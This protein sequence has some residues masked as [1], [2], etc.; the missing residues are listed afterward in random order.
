LNQYHTL[1]IIALEQTLISG[2][3]IHFSMFFF[4]KYLKIIM[5]F[6][7]IIFW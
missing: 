4:F 2:W 6:L 3:I 5:Y 1:I 7:S